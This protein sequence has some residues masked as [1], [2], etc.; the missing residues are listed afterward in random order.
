MKFLIDAQLPPVLSHYLIWKGYDCIHTDDL[1]HKERTSDTEIRGVAIAQNRIV[2]T[3]D[4]D[5]VDS[6]F[7]SGIQKNYCW[8][9][10]EISETRY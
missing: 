1:P 5:F 9:L 3:K 7:I 4:Y 8:F 10:Q 6:Y 2:I